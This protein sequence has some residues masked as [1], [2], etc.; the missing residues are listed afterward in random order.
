[1]T[2]PPGDLSKIQEILLGGTKFLLTSHARPDGDSLGSQ[3]ALGRALSQLG[4][5]VRIVNKDQIPE[6]YHFL[7][8]LET[9]EIL[10]ETDSLVDAVVVLE[11]SSLSR[12]EVSGLNSGTIVN[13]DHHP[14][15]TMYGTINWVDESACACTEL[16][17]ELIEGLGAELT[18]D[19]ATNLYVGTL[20]DTGSFRYSNITARTFEICRR[21][22]ETGIDLA[23]I[24]ASIYTNGSIGRLRLTGRLLDRMKL[25]H[26]NQIAVLSVDSA[27]LQEIG[28]DW[29]DM[30][31][32]VNLPLAA[33][34]VRVSILVRETNA[35]LRV[36]LRSKTGTNVRNAALAF[37]GGGHINAAGLTI[38]NP[39]PKSLDTIISRIKFTI[40]DSEE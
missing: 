22:A 2:P 13:I 40:S 18:P 16:V 32:I 24:A 20:T 26:N 6:L 15:N 35:G 7:P 30:E 17:F 4:K 5:D 25:E 19:I 1:M 9:I 37:G 12:T 28:C 33:R 3:L 36:S 34:N 14:G 10:P 39:G 38:E 21:L 23:A 31:G 27:M 8:G 11:C 29:D